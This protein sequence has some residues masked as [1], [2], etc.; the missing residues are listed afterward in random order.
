MML[1]QIL[2]TIPFIW[3]TDLKKCRVHAFEPNPVT[4][5]RLCRHISINGM[6]GIIKAHRVAL[7]DKEETANLIDE[8]YDNSGAARLG[9]D[10]PGIP[11]E[12]TTLDA[13]CQKHAENRLD[14][15]KIDVEGRE[16]QFIEGARITLERFKPALVAEFWPPGLRRAGTVV[17]DM[18]Q[19]LD[20]M[21]Y[22]L[23][24]AVRKRLEPIN[25]LPRGNDPI[26]IF[27]FHKERPPR[28]LR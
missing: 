10:A 2:V 18:A 1:G 9:S 5:E 19:V 14:A 11:V 3:H 23:Y 17:D 26:N 7:S 24:K 8:R 16:V 22:E 28:S 12:V 13:F 4:H 21:G 20:G 27:A 15:I 6:T 25:E